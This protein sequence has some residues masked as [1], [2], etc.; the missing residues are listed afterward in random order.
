MRYM[1]RLHVSEPTT[2]MGGNVPFAEGGDVS[3]FGP[4]RIHMFTIDTANTYSVYTERVQYNQGQVDASNI[5]NVKQ[6]GLMDILV[7]GGGGG[8][9]CM[10]GGG[11]AGGYQ[12]FTNISVRAGAIPITVGAGGRSERSHDANTQTAGSP[13]VFDVGGLALTAS[14]GGKGISYGF[15]FTASNPT[16]TAAGA[17]GGGGPGYGAGNY[18]GDGVT[19]PAGTGIPGQ[20]H[21]GGRGHHGPWGHAGGGGGGAGQAGFN[22]D[23]PNHGQRSSLPAP[24]GSGN[25]LNLYPPASPYPAFPTSQAGGNGLSN[26][27][28]GSVNHFAGGG[29][30]GGHPGH[31][32]LRTKG[33]LGG[34]G[35]GVSNAH[36]NN[37]PLGNDTYHNSGQSGQKNTGGGGGGSTHS[38]HAN[39]YSGRG[40][41]GV[42]IVRYRT[43]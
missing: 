23:T 42:V 6:A 28:L 27:I 36:Q 21:P 30:G 29:G 19:T 24:N 37:V 2:T 40:G 41:S 8:G 10:G 17:S 38:G 22:Y 1:Q 31:A 32:W 33:G 13:S 34:G 5:F 4:Y 7:V 35:Q 26:D 11:G 3:Q 9:A 25:R 43:R 39:S 20:G 12:F 16:P 14:G 18:N 15:T